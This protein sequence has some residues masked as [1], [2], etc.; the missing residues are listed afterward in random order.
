MYAPMSC[1]LGLTESCADEK[2]KS[3]PL[4]AGRLGFYKRGVGREAGRQGLQ[5]MEAV[6]ME[7]SERR[8]RIIPYQGRW[9]V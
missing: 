3:L 1:G 8:C 9:R 7:G 4:Y 6:H 5:Y 2:A